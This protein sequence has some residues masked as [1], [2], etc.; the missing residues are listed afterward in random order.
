MDAPCKMQSVESGIVKIH[1]IIDLRAQDGFNRI[2]RLK[3]WEI[4]IAP[5]HDGYMQLGLFC[6]LIVP[7]E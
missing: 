6:Y 1:V 5:L 7:I 3:L 4:V 2:S